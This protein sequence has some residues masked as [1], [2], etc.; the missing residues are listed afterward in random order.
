MSVQTLPSLQPVQ[1]GL[2]V[3]LC[4]VIV[5]NLFQATGATFRLGT[6][7]VRLRLDR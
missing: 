4:K 6:K 3:F 7:R 5:Y 2:G 1:I